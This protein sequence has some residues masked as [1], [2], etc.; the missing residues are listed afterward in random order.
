MH[1]R[2]N[3]RANDHR[4]TSREIEKKM[5]ALE[6]V[7]SNSSIKHDHYDIWKV[8]NIEKERRRHVPDEI[9][10]QNQFNYGST[11]NIQF[12]Y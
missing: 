3:N 6:R 11:V 12:I 5:E 8:L 9:T 7:K 2:L 1:T 4:I 10:Q